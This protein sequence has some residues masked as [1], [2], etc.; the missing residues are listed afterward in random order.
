[1]ALTDLPVALVA[2]NAQH[3]VAFHAFVTLGTGKT[4]ETTEPLRL[5]KGSLSPT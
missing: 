5:P 3:D 1:M 2:Y 4:V